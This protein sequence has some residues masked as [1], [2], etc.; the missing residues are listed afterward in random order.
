MHL[1]TVVENEFGGF[2]NVFQNEIYTLSQRAVYHAKNEVKEKIHL[3]THPKELYGK[4]KKLAKE[5]GIPFA[6][7]AVGLEIVKNVIA[8]AI[9]INRGYPEYAAL[10]IAVHAEPVMYPLYFGVRKL[11]KYLR[12]RE[13]GRSEY[14]TGEGSLRYATDSN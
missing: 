6:C 5:E 4:V 7:Y 2:D 3:L 1:E 8:P 13:R 12:G 10:T 11:V 9:L 14:L